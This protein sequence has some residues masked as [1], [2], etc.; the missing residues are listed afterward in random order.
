MVTAE[1]EGDDAYVTGQEPEPE[2]VQVGGEGRV[3]APLADHDTVPVG[4]Y[5]ETVA[6]HVELDPTNTGEGEQLTAV[7][8]VALVTVTDALTGVP[9]L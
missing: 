2:S 1:S 3:P 7:V 6:M 9:G 4:L 8:G 5:P